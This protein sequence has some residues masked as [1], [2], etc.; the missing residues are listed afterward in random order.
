MT[1]V[2]G[3]IVSEIKKKT[4]NRLNIAPGRVIRPRRMQIRRFVRQFQI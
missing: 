3:E 1:Y 2:N 4:P